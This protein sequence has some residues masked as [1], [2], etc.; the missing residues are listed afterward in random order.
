[1]RIPL[2]IKIRRGDKLVEED[3]LL[4]ID[5]CPPQYKRGKN[6]KRKNRKFKYGEQEKFRRE[7]TPRRSGRAD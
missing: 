7:P 4:W 1:M 3:A 2:R 5:E 6:R